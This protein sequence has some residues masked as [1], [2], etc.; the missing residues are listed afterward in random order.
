MKISVF[1]VVSHI[2]VYDTVIL[3][4]TASQTGGSSL[5]TQHPDN[6]TVRQSVPTGNRTAVCYL[7]CPGFSRKAMVRQWI[8]LTRVGGGKTEGLGGEMRYG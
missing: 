6:V 7:S 2:I 5:R 4:H 3:N 8:A 1:F